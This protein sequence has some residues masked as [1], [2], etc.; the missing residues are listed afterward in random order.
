MC[1]STLST[2]SC[3][4]QGFSLCIIVI[5]FLL[6]SLL[7]QWAKVYL[8]LFHSTR[9]ILAWRWVD[10]WITLDVPIMLDTFWKLTLSALH[11]QTPIL[12]PSNQSTNK[13][14]N[15]ST[16]WQANVLS[17]QPTKWLTSP[18]INQQTDLITKQPINPS[19]YSQPTKQPLN[20]LTNQA[21]L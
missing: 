8:P 7:F 11:H 5:S 17:K 10:G 16:S 3:F 21:T 1:L 9:Y 14:T 13:P 4:S 12:Q 2:A 15:P 6:P 20:L 19:F 18:S